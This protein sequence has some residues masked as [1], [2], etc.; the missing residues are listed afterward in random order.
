MSEINH[1]PPL[2]AKKSD[3]IMALLLLACILVFSIATIYSVYTQRSQLLLQECR[4][5]E[6]LP[7]FSW[8]NPTNFTKGCEAALADHFF[9]RHYF[10]QPR[11]DF[12][13][14]FVKCSAQGNVR[15]GK[16]GWLFLGGDDLV[17]E[18]YGLKPFTEAQL[19]SLQ[20]MFEARALWLKKRNCRY[21]ILPTPAKETIYPETAG[22]TTARGRRRLAQFIDWMGKNSFV[23]VIDLTNDLR[24]AART[25]QV[26]A[27]FDTHWNSTGAFIGYRTLML[28]LSKWFPNLH[29]LQ[30]NELIAQTGPAR[31]QFDLGR[32]LHISPGPEAEKLFELA[33]KSPTYSTGKDAPWIWTSTN[34]NPRLPRAAVLRDSFFEFIQPLFAQHFSQVSYIASF[35]FPVEIFAALKPDIVVQEFNERYLCLEPLFGMDLDRLQVEEVS[36]RNKNFF[37]TAPGSE[38]I[39]FGPVVKLKKAS[40]VRLPQRLLL[41]TLWTAGDHP[42]QGRFV[43]V[44]VLDQDGNILTQYDHK[45]ILKK[46][47]KNEEF[48][49]YLA[50]SQNCLH[51][52][53]WIGLSIYADAQH[54]HAVH[55]GHC[56]LDNH[57]LLLALPEPSGKDK[58]NE[59]HLCLKL[60]GIDLAPLPVGEAS[61]PN[62]DFFT[63]APG[64]DGIIFGPVV[65]LEKASMVR[66][67]QQLLLKTLWTAG[68]HADE[69]RFVGVHV[70]DQDGNILS[71]YDHKLILKKYI[72]NQEFTDDL[73]IP[74]NCLHGAKWIGLSIYADAQHV[75]AVRGGHCDLE[76][77]RLLLAL[78]EPPGKDKFKERDLSLKQ[79][80][81]IDL[82]L[83]QVKKASKRKE[84][85]F[86]TAPGSEGIIFGPVVKLEKASMVRLPQQLLLKT[87]WTAG[88]HPDEGQFVGVH[89]LDQDGNILTQYDHKLILRKYLKNEEFKI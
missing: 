41:K 67:P 83:L 49:D 55:G 50:I 31:F 58:V 39:I 25:R 51:D 64:S 63:T 23:E 81:G 69:G 82:A 59:S 62:E 3:Q 13:Y 76:N 17:T 7:K 71:Q 30:E 66:L 46:Y 61:K 32:M 88:D 18:F 47:S 74:Q 87:L 72:K 65:K 79:L 1:Q 52:A 27:K 14:H 21:V 42:D 6:D 89:V 10:L 28:R 26:Y 19:I 29:P 60:F 16:D 77:H 78:P 85:F 34:E 4:N 11:A 33:P 22:S 37:T 80:F 2:M 35:D 56:D 36:E 43:G 48:T 38:G 15:I 57:R 73:A 68:D 84:D 53:K 20:K 75:Q 5:S 86:T 54:V 40:M 12:L 9:L 24:D 70:L 8:T 44:H 45:L